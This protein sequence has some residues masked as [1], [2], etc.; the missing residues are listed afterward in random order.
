MT[1]AGAAEADADADEE[2][3]AA[4]EEE[5]AGVEE[6]WARLVELVRAMQRFLKLLLVTSRATNGSTGTGTGM[7]AGSAE[8]ALA[9]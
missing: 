5:A 7:G 6:G 3:G 9:N 2:A 8:R 4:D 1:G